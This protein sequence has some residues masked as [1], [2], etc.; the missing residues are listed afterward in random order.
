MTDPAPAGGATEPGGATGDDRRSGWARPGVVALGLL[1]A[2]TIVATAIALL[3]GS[4]P[5]DTA[6]LVAVA[7]GGAVVAAGAGWWALGPLRR[8][9]V[10]AQAIVV[11]VV[12]VLA[13]GVG[14]MAA[15]RAMFISS[16]DLGALLVVLVAAG[17]AGTAAALRL[18]WHAYSGTRD[19]ERL[20]GRLGRGV[21]PEGGP[22]VPP[23]TA[24]L[25]RLADRIAEVSA[26]LEIAREREQALQRSRRQLIAWISHDLRGPLSSIRAMAEA[27]ED[28]VVDDPATV[29]RY[30]TAT[31]RET[32]RLSQMVDDLFELS[33]IT[34]GAT[35]VRPERVPLGGVLDEAADTVVA[36]AERSEVRIRRE[37]GELPSVLASVAE[38]TRVLHN[39]LDNAIRHTPAGGV[40][41]VSAEV[42]RAGATRIVVTDQCGGIP[43][44]DLDRVFDLAFRGDDARGRDGGGGLGLTIAKGLVEALDG[45]LEV[46]NLDVGCRFTV[47]LPSAGDARPGTEPARPASRAL[48]VSR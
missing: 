21:A 42:D 11:V 18:G 8:T 13:T 10:R 40:V 34:A 24:E 20:A 27:L 47:T 39:L 5:E 7:A 17:S 41:S 4:S 43:D 45:S 26:D 25:A 36:R 33:R 29:A 12:V 22:A 28:G 2:G 1:V 37:Y 35:S 30:H 15:A 19:V 32:E 14:V 44:E 6:V 23:A 48:P 9:S 46:D 3:W 31:R 38:L 16:H